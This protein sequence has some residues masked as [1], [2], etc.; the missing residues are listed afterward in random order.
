[1]GLQPNWHSIQRPLND[2]RWTDFERDITSDALV[3]EKGGILFFARLN[4]FLAEAGA[5][6]NRSNKSY[7]TIEIDDQG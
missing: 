1:M 4:L 7:R 5:D 6:T 2:S 3:E